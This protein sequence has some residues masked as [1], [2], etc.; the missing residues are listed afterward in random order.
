M[1]TSAAQL[2]GLRLKA[3]QAGRIALDT[4]F[5]WERTYY[6]RLGLVQAALPGDRWYL[7]DTPAI[8]D[9]SSLGKILSTAN[10]EKVLHDAQLD[11][12][13]LCQQTGAF[14]DNVFDTRLAAGFAGLLSTISLQDLVEAV[15]NVRLSKGETRTNWLKRPLTERQQEYAVDDV[16][17]LLGIRDYLQTAVRSS[18]RDAWLAEELAMFDDPDRYEETDPKLVFQ[19]LKGV[20]RL[21]SRQLTTLRELACWREIQAR[22]RDRPRQWILADKTLIRIA[23]TT[24]ASEQALLDD[25][26][27][28]ARHVERYGCE[29]LK[30][31]AEAGHMPLSSWSPPSRFDRKLNRRV[32]EILDFIK[33]RCGESGVDV[34]LVITKGKLRDVITKRTNPGITTNGIFNGWREDFVGAE[35]KKRFFPD[36]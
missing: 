36:R 21:D 27:L 5:V 29:L 15:M 35:V 9:L 10:I 22:R 12:S 2:D 7:I 13:I 3:L 4:E 26:E 8:G 23:A 31:V 33:C 32:D 34:Q 28:P 6:P 1:I 20:G 14:P 17:Y 19:K 30:I 24:P 25:C 11:L 16:R 18:K